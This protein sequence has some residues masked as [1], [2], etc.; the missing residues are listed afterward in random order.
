[1]TGS[2]KSPKQQDAAPCQSLFVA[3]GSLLSLAPLSIKAASA[4]VTEK[5]RHNKAPQGALF[6][7]GARVGA[8]LVGVAIIGRPIA[9]MLA[10]GGTCEV[11]RL[12]TD[13]TP[14]ACSMLY[15]AAAR[16][17]KALGYDRVITYILTSEPG[18]SLRAS[19]WIKD[20]AVKAEHSWTRPSRSRVNAERP[21]GPKTRWV[22]RL[23]ANTQFSNAVNGSH[24]QTGPSNGV[25]L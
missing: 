18:T 14:N 5:H 22:R 7:V 20:A 24:P 4:F 10:D 11:T 19:G 13:G 6:A 9:R 21:T 3:T 8:Q 15:G 16:A 1:M 12:C 23:S 25:A 2:L 17:A